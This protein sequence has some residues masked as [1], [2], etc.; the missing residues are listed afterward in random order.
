MAYRAVRQRVM[1]FKYL[2]GCV[3]DYGKAC[4][5]GWVLTE[6]EVC[7]PPAD[8][9]GLCR[10]VSFQGSVAEIEN[11]TLKCR[12]N[13]PCL[14]ACRA[15]YSQPCPDSWVDVEGLCV[16]PFDYAGICSAAMDL[17]SFTK[18]RKAHLAAQCRVQWPCEHNSATP[19][20]GGGPL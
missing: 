15:A 11:L 2:G 20:E 13:W 12:A 17:R 4:P 3:R 6:T 14:D 19:V 7:E 9:S 1:S 18:S 16:A 10:P 5:Q 8:Y